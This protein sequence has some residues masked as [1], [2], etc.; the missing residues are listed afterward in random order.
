MLDFLIKNGTL[1]DGSGRRRYQADIGISGD[2][3]VAIE[4]LSDTES[5]EIIQADGLVVT[6]GFIDMHSHA[7][8]TLPILPT[9]DSKVQQGVTFELVGNCGI[10]PSP[11]DDI[12]R[13]AAI[14]NTVLGGPGLD[15]EWDTFSSYLDRLRAIGTSVNVGALIG[16][17][18]IRTHVMGEGDEAA[19]DSQL[20]RMTDEVRLAMEA[21]AFG[22]STGL[23]YPPNVYSSTD[24]IVALA[25]C[26]A[27]RGGIY[28]SHIRGEADTVL[29]AVDEAIEIGK[30]ANI[31]VEISHLKAQDH[32]NWH[33]M[34][35]LLD[36]IEQARAAGLDVSADMYPYTACNTSLSSLLSAWAHVGGKTAML[37]RLQDAGDRARMGKELTELAVHDQPGF[38]ERTFIAYCPK[39]AEFEGRHLQEIAAG[40]G[41]SPENAVMDILL[42]AVS[43]VEM[44]QFL[45]SDENVEL[46]LSSPHVMI[47]SDGEGRSTEGPLSAGVPHPR[48]YGTFP[49]VLGHYSREKNLF[50]LE[51]AVYKMSGLPADKLRLEQRGRLKAGNYADIV[52]FDPLKIIDRASYASPHQYPDGIHYVFVNGK[53]VVRNGMHTQARPGMVITRN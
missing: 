22:L 43:G 38:W 11:I 41:L 3:I 51:E 33:K 25:R 1:I 23:I 50:S 15:W 13:P 2:R 37:N 6:P 21:G 47:G 32:P 14:A 29:E 24:E 44:T 40:L 5:V 46:G 42:E 20:Q 49:R 53:I 39:R 7:D 10:S 8:F 35:I 9:A 52:V 4:N 48:N 30:R 31:P 17:G 16:H 19:D 12:S 34:P 28:A 27:S 26:A 36:K 45:M 18:A